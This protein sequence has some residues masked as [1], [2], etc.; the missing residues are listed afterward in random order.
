[1]DVLGLLQDEPDDFLKGG[2][3][4]GGLDEQQI[5]QLIA[6]RKAAKAGKNWA[7]ADSIRDQLKGQGIILED[8]AGG[9]TIW[10][11]EG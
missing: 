1:M 3:T 9:N 2:A 7:L 4:A 5:E 11:R 10:R 8:V 6:D